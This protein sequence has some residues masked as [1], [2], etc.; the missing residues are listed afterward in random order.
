MVIR[1]LLCS[2]I[3]L[4][5]AVAAACLPAADTP[6]VALSDIVEIPAGRWLLG[7]DASYAMRN[8]RPQ[9]MVSLPRFGIER[10]PVSNRQF[11]RF[12]AETGYQTIAERPVDWEELRQQVPPGTPKPADELLQPGSLVFAGSDGPVDLSD[13]RQWWRWT[14]GANWRHP[15]GPGSSI[16]ERMDH[17]VVHIAWPDAMAYAVWAGRRLPSEDEW[18]AAARGGLVGTRYSWGD[19]FAPDGQFQ[20]N[21]FTG[22]FPHA[23]DAADGFVG[24]API[25]SFPANGYGLYDMA[26]NVW[27]WT[28]SRYATRAGDTP[29]RGDVRRVIKGGSYLCHPDYCESYR[30]AARRGTPADTGSSHVGFRCAVDL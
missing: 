23:N 9:R 18:E 10:T 20:T 29:R 19:A 21:S 24:V 3:S 6:E 1:P 8:E 4:S 12:V 11:A 22:A 25:A 14:V 5:L 7:S 28:A 13:L 15:E 16:L 30:P 27:Q 26:G 17:P 2:V